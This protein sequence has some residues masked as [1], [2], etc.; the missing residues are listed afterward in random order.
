MLLTR[1]M[2]RKLAVVMLC[3][4]GLL[5]LFV[6]VSIHGLYSHHATLDDLRISVVD[7][8]SRDQLTARISSL[9]EPLSYRIPEETRDPELRARAAQWQY[10]QFARQVSDVY[11]EMVEF[12]SKWQALNQNLPQSAEHEQTTSTFLRDLRDTLKNELAV[13]ASP[14]QETDDLDRRNRHIADMIRTIGNMIRDVESLPDPAYQLSARLD[15]A[16]ASYD[17]HVVL[18]RLVGAVSVLTVAGLMAWMYRLILAPIYSLMKGVQRVAAGEF[19]YRLETSTKC[20]LSALATAFNNMAAKIESD[21]REKEHRIE[22]GIQQLIQ[23]ERM[24]SLGMLSTGVA[25]EINNP[26]MGIANAGAELTFILGDY[27]GAMKPQD[28]QDA[29]LALKIITEQTRNSQKIISKLKLFGQGKK[30][31]ERN[32]YDVTAIVQEVVS[33]VQILKQ[34]PDRAISVHQSQ[35]FRAWIDAGEIRQ[36]VLNLVMNALQAMEPGGK[37][38]I[39]MRETPDFIELEFT[40]TGCGMTEDQLKQIFVPFFTTKEVGQGTGLG[41]SLSRS[42]V[43]NHGG[44]L[45]ATSAGP[46]QG[47]TFILRLPRT[48]PSASRN[49]RVA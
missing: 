33:L 22:E 40:D 34:F 18:L 45:E 48:A 47:S 19:E 39:D 36:V 21:R 10:E 13:G 17:S 42:I 5:S 15:E 38:D 9:I 29:E 25:H 11:D 20:E 26:L 6:G 16:Q 1:S 8:P 2:R 3:V 27:K 14:L 32:Q 31:E 7:A 43:L 37:L 28:I 30:N 44:N 46:Q 4:V 24:A 23:S 41:L 12:E 49:T 35:T